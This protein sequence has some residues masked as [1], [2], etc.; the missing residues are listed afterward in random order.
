MPN[1]TGPGWGGRRTHHTRTGRVREDDAPVGK[2]KRNSGRTQGSGARQDRQGNLQVAPTAPAEM[3]VEEAVPGG[4]LVTRHLRIG[5]MS[6]TACQEKVQRKLRRSRGVTSASVDFAKGVADV[7][8]N[9]A[10]TSVEALCQAIEKIGYQASALSDA[11]AHRMHTAGEKPPVGRVVAVM[12][13]II[14]AF[15]VLQQFGV[16][17]L[18]VPSQLADTSMG[19]GMLF[20]VGLLTSV[21]C[22]AMC[23]GINI[24]QCLV[25][26][27]AEPADTGDRASS[28][29]RSRFAAY[30]PAALYNL[31][32]VVSYTVIGFVLGL[33][34]MIAGGSG[35]G[36]SPVLQGVLKIVAGMLMVV[37][38]V[39]ML[40]LFPALR[41]FAPRLP[42]GL[43]E[44]L[45]VGRLRGRGPL[46]V[47]LLNGLMPCGPMQSMQ[48]V[49]LA[50][51]S[52]LVGAA[53]MLLFS[54]GTV[55][56]ML[57]LGSLVAA[58]GRRF[59]H[60]VM[61]V[62]S[63]LVVVL[64]LAMLSQ[65]V[66]L[67]GALTQGTFVAL[68][69]CA[70][71]LGIVASVPFRSATASTLTVGAT[72]CVGLLLVG[73]MDLWKA[74]APSAVSAT[75][76]ALSEG[77]PTPLA[78]GGAGGATSLSDDGTQLVSNTLQ[79]G[80]YPNITVEAGQPVRWTI[81]APAGSLNACNSR[82]IIRDFGIQQ[83]LQSGDNVIEFTP[84]ERGTISYSCWMG[85]VR[86]T[87][88]VV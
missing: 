11:A 28:G 54:L 27:G 73:T 55:P 42:A 16:L 75:R 34:G 82:V 24:S 8:F 60:Q 29:L 1:T 50:S 19:Y 47:G 15:I 86:G 20:V 39:N 81:S 66:S 53:S 57:G 59:V 58:L 56:L 40:G 23:G 52:P 71:V 21:H 77:A 22:V 30:V 76:G 48:I 2:K 67:S 7:T 61:R 85:M 78:S 12:A 45:G 80:R 36:L 14:V 49:A 4:E 46:V 64:G 35:A 79:L 37:M 25:H 17:N 31:G 68:V 13:I 83:A 33:A 5:G 51:G 74:P 44:R 84:T 41:R 69:V 43:S 70:A 32:R 18:L 63:V 87:I 26:E 88:T 38:G 6:C 10:S 65:G 72:A 3:A 9:P 62:G